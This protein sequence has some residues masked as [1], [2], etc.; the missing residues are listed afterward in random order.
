MLFIRPRESKRQP[1][2]RR[3]LS[4]CLSAESASDRVGDFLGCI[5]LDEVPA[6]SN[7]MTT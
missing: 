3:R 1:L 4:V 5:L 6:W 2:P 7:P